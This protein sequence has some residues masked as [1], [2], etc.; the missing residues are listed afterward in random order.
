MNR[1]NCETQIFGHLKGG[2]RLCL[3]TL[4]T[5]DQQQNTLDGLERARHLVRE[6]DMSGCIDKIEFIHHTGM[7]VPHPNWLHLDGNPPLTLKIHRVQHLLFHESCLD[8]F[9]D[10]EHTIGERRFAVVNM[11]DDTKVA[12]MLHRMAV[13][14]SI[15][16][17]R[18]SFNKPYTR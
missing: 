15:Y 18:A 16:S 11:R 8:G 1:N 10:F 12:N 5:I 7:L 13:L 4:S 9:G 17:F 14:Y 3:H 2:K 6:V